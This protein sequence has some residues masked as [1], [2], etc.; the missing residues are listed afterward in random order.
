MSKIILVDVD[1]APPLPPPSRD[2]RRGALSEAL[3]SMKPNQFLFIPG[4]DANKIASHSRAFMKRHGRRV[5]TRT[6]TFRGG[7]GVGDADHVGHDPNGDARPRLHQHGNG[8]L[9]LLT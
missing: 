9:N 4:G 8:A 7:K 6:I 3:M 1:E 2:N 5:M